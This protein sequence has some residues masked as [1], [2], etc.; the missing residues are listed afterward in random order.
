M[1]FVIEYYLE[2]II[3]MLSFVPPLSEKKKRRDKDDTVVE[4]E[5]RM[6]GGEACFSCLFVLRRSECSQASLTVFIIY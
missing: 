5:V 2:D 3:E 6:Q 4:E 1:I